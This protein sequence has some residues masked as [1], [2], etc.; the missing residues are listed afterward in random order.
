M[1]APLLWFLLGL[2]FLAAELATPTLVLLFFGAGAWA[3]A[4][5]ALLGLAVSTQVEVFILVSLLTLMLLRRHVRAVFHGRARQAED[6]DGAHD[7]DGEAAPPHPLTGRTGVVSKALRPGAV[8]EVRVD[9]SF[10]RAM[11]AA[12]LAAGSPVRVTG[13]QP[14]DTLV[15]RVER[16]PTDGQERVQA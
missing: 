6:A 12:P 10:W 15:L 16:C 13:S 2:A 5:S 14:G 7:P 3:A 4:C 9:G 11:A 1:S 8:G